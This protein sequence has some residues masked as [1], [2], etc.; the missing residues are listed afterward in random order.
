MQLMIRL[1]LVLIPLLFLACSGKSNHHDEILLKLEK[2]LTEELKAITETYSEQNHSFIYDILE[3]N[4]V[5][6]QVVHSSLIKEL[7][8]N[9]TEFGLAIAISFDPTFSEEVENYEKFKNSTYSSKFTAYEWHSIPCFGL[10]LKTD[11]E[12]TAVM[13]TGILKDVYG[14]NESTNFSTQFYD[15]GAL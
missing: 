13:L 4:D 11:F 12:A 3:N 5:R 9:P 10:N 2:Q 14:F 15:Q 8:T 7:K 1:F 6:I